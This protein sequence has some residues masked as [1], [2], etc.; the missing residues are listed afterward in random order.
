MFRSDLSWHAHHFNLLEEF[1][2]RMRSRWC[3]L[4]NRQQCGST[5][6]WRQAKDRNRHATKVEAVPGRRCHSCGVKG[7]LFS[8]VGRAPPASS[9]SFLLQLTKVK[10][11]RGGVGL[12][13]PARAR[14]AAAGARWHTEFL[15]ECSIFCR[16]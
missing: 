11:T 5:I 6:T 13:T 7:S 8:L 12:P 16:I 3:G 10:P 1:S 9:L 15:C 2:W 4:H 14:V